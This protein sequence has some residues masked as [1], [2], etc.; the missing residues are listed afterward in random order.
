MLAVLGA[1]EAVETA[2][3]VDLTL[4]GERLTHRDLLRQGVSPADGLEP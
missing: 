4:R 1:C 3:D 2:S